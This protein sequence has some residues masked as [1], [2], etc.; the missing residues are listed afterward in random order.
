MKP[1]MATAITIV[2]ANSCKILPMIPPM[3]IRGMKTVHRHS[4][5][6]KIVKP[7]CLEPFK[8]A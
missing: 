3:K 5:I 1:E 7:I 8:A 2:I 4:V 6:D